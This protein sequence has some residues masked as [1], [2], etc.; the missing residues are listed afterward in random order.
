MNGQ[1]D[2]LGKFHHAAVVFS[3]LPANVDDH[4]QA[5]QTL[6]HAKVLRQQATP[7]PSLL[8]RD[9]GESITGQIH[10]SLTITEA[11]EIH[12][13][14]AP[15]DLAGTGELAAIDDH[16]DRARFT[17]I[18]AAGHGDLGPGIRHKLADSVGAG[19]KPGFRV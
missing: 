3:E 5:A 19:Q 4:D 15:R 2:D 14:G 1:L 7:V 16:I 9:A 6:S 8:V 12:Q 18:R 17:C 13:L 11:E 10:Q